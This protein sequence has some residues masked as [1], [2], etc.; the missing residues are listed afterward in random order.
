LALVL[1]SAI[2]FERELSQKSAGLRT[3]TL[4]ELGEIEGVLSV[5]AGDVNEMFD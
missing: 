2:G 4:A 1:S 5:A 3:Y